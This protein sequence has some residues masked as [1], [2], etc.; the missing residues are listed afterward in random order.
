MRTL[1]LAALLAFITLASASASASTPWLA[2]ACAAR[3][4]VA[5]GG[6]LN[7]CGCHFNRKTGE[8]HCHQARGCGCTCQPAGCG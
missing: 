3:G 7:A 2:S 4:L 1:G 6:G 8:C 5:H